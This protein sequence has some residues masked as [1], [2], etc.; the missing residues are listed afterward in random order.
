MS[1]EIK[2]FWYVYDEYALTMLPGRV[3][4]EIMYVA[5]ETHEES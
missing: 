3:I 1:T 5:Y 4:G 2:E